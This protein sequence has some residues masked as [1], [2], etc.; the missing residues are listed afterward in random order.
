[1]KDQIYSLDAPNAWGYNSSMG[2]EYIIIS[3]ITNE[4]THYVIDNGRSIKKVNFWFQVI[5]FFEHNN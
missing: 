4:K 3:A 1:M 2:N 5:Q